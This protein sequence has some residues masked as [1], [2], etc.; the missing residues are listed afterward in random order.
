MGAGKSMS[1]PAPPWLTRGVGYSQLLLGAG[2]RAE[3]DLAGARVGGLDADEDTGAGLAN[4][5]CGSFSDGMGAGRVD[6]PGPPPMD[7]AILGLANAPLMGA[8]ILGG[9]RESRSSRSFPLEEVDPRAP[10]RTPPRSIDMERTE[11]D[12][13][14]GRCPREVGELR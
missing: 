12:L 6:L 8:L 10:P 2:R 1:S 14:N 5:D 3:E 11:D 9:G 13:D 4:E 7:E